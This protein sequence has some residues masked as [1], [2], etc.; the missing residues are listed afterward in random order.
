MYDHIWGLER[1]FLAISLLSDFIFLNC[2]LLYLTWHNLVEAKALKDRAWSS[3][4]S[5]LLNYCFILSSHF[6]LKAH[7]PSWSFLSYAQLL[8]LADWHCSLRSV[9]LDLASHFGLCLVLELHWFFFLIQDINRHCT[10]Q[11]EDSKTTVFNV[12]SINA[13]HQGIILRSP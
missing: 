11:K 6:G 3:L 5:F 4:P 7:W 9:G 2:V 10:Q 13:D 12:W 8:A 1:I